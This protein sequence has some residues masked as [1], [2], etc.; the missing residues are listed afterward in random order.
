MQFEKQ[1]QHRIGELSWIE[2]PDWFA[3][4]RTLESLP[5]ISSVDPGLEIACDYGKKSL[6]WT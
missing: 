4:F 6:L 1:G 3:L 5:Y 2:R